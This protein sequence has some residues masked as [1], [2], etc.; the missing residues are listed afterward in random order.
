MAGEHGGF[1][2]QCEQMCAYALYQGIEVAA[3]QVCPSRPLGLGFQVSPLGDSEPAAAPLH[4]PGH[5]A[6]SGGDWGGT[7]PKIPGQV[8]VAGAGR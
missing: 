6:G 8:T 5:C 2:G 4:G 3:R 1:A 7:P